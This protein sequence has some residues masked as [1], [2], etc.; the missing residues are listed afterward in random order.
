M[1]ENKA[2]RVN[3]GPWRKLLAL[4]ALLGAAAAVYFIGYLPRQRTTKQIEAAAALRRV[5][6][7]LVNAAIVKRAAPSSELLLPGNITR[8]PP[9]I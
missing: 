7:P 4:A 5:T 2:G 6:P 3:R 9:D 8:A 1:I